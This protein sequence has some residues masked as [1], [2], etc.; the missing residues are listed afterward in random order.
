MEK[1]NKDWF[2]LYC[3]LQTSILVGTGASLQKWFDIT[4]F[5]DV[6]VL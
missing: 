5:E 6:K 4:I 3:F 1:L 2:K